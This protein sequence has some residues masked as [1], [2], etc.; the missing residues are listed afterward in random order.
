MYSDKYVFPER[1]VS[2]HIFEMSAEWLNKHVSRFSLA[3]PKVREKPTRQLRY[4]LD[5]IQ[6][7]AEDLLGRG[8][9]SPER[10][11]RIVTVLKSLSWLWEEKNA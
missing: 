7:V 8:Y 5:D 11:V 4:T 9:I 2:V 3:V 1:W 6:T 10:F